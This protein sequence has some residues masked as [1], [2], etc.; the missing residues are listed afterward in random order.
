LSSAGAGAG[1]NAEPPLEFHILRE[2][3][4][5]STALSRKSQ[6]DPFIES[7][8]LILPGKDGKEFH[9]HMTD[10]QIGAFS[11]SGA[12]LEGKI[13]ETFSLNPRT[14]RFEDPD[15]PEPPP[16]RIEWGPPEPRTGG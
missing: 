11:V 12:S 6:N 2:T 16:R 3:D 4:K 7:L 10:V 13:F 8:T 15:N 1:R 14:V 9:I 5:V